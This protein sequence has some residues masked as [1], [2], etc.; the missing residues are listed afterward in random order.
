[1]SPYPPPYRGRVWEV[2]RN[3]PLAR[4][5]C[6]VPL[7]CWPFFPT[8]KPSDPVAARYGD[9]SSVLRRDAPQGV[10]GSPW[11]PK[12]RDPNDGDGVGASRGRVPARP[13][14]SESDRQGA[15]GNGARRGRGVGLSPHKQVELGEAWIPDENYRAKCGNPFGEPRPT[16]HAKRV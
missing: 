12:A 14:R 9:G 10:Q 15:Q 6:P 3:G 7:L 2:G 4:P 1:M 11:S 16:K 8:F 5:V 13:E